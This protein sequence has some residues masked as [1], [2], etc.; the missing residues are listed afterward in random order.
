VSARLIGRLYETGRADG[1]LDVERLAGYQLADEAFWAEIEQTTQ[2]LSQQALD[3][4]APYGDC[5]LAG[6]IR[7][8]M[9]QHAEQWAAGREYRANMRQMFGIESPAVC[10]PV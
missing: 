8:Q 2:G 5:R 3:H 4:L 1:G 9:A 6:L 7:R 10:E